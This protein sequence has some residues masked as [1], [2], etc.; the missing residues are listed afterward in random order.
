MTIFL[1]FLLVPKHTANYFL[2]LVQVVS[3]FVPL[4]SWFCCVSQSNLI[5]SL[6]LCILLSPELNEEHLIFKSCYLST[7]LIFRAK[8]K[9]MSLLLMY[10]RNLCPPVSPS[11]PT[12]TPPALAPL[13]LRWASYKIISSRCLSL[14][15]S[16]SL[17]S[18]ISV[19][20]GV[21]LGY[22]FLITAICLTFCL[23]S[24]ISLSKWKI[25]SQI[26]SSLFVGVF[27][28]FFHNFYQKHHQC[29]SRTCWIAC[30]LLYF[31]NRNPDSLN[32]LLSLNPVL[33]MILQITSKNSHPA[34]HPGLVACHKLSLL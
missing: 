4:S 19:L 5:F 3:Y 34:D 30:V 2:L 22:H 29:I 27:S 16:T 14:L 18:T 20:P 23:N 33:W 26:F 31:P 8:W 28:V 32:P 6:P 13:S 7:F 25:K 10:L 9:I 17:K 1:T 15:K 11:P 24:L 21:L 12:P